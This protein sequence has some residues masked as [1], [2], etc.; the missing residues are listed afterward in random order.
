MAK[1]AF[2]P[3]AFEPTA[4]GRWVAVCSCGWRSA[5]HTSAGRAGAEADEHR[6]DDPSHQQPSP[7]G[8]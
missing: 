7:A 5:P 2:R 1:E 3:M 4:S 8:P 6:R